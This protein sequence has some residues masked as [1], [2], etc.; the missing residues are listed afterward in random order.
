MISNFA[1]CSRNG[2]FITAGRAG[3]RERSCGVGQRGEVRVNLSAGHD[4]QRQAEQWG[5]ARLMP[6]AA[7]AI[8]WRSS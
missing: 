5:Q 8:I 4:E 3:G 6:R 7:A 2:E 1:F